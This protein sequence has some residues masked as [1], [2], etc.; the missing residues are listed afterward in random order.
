MNSKTMLN[1]IDGEWRQAS[2]T[3]CQDIV[4]P[5]TQDLLGYVPFSTAQDISAAVDAASQALPDWRRVPPTER[6]Q[7]LFALKTLLEKHRQELARLITM[8]CGKTLDESLGE[9]QRADRECRDGLW[10]PGLTSGSHLGGYR[11]RH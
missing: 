9:L 5:A 10:H 7:Y 11:S 6:V 2:S 1:F 3:D 4:N 8:E